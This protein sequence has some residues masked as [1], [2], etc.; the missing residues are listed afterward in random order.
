LN[1]STATAFVVAAC[2]VTVAKHGNRALT[3]RAGGSDVLSALGVDMDVPPAGLERQLREHGLAFLFA[4]RHH[5]ALR[6]AAPVRSE[7]GFRTIFNLLGPLSNPAGVRLQL[8]GV[9]DPAWCVPMAETLGALGTERAWLVHGQGLDE[10]TLAGETQVV[11]WHR[12][13]LR[14]FCVTPAQAGL[15][16]TPVDAIRGGDA[17]HNAAALRALLQGA[18]G[19]YRDMVLLNAAASLIVAGR[20]ADLREG[21]SLAEA[22]LDRGAALDVMERLVR[23]AT[24]K[25]GP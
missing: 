24:R 10:L 4:P 20:A 15:P 22:A 1:V 18:P 23:D 19:A 17:A 12:G 8:T 14:Q 11:E 6:H 16:E 2:G 3:S 21:V 9:Y 7:I 25:A 13:S 5:P